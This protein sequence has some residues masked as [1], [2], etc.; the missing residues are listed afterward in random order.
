[1]QE[2]YEDN[3][4]ITDY[5]RFTALKAHK[6]YLFIGGSNGDIIKVTLRSDLT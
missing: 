4:E 2:I 3:R 1:M 5:S 6:N